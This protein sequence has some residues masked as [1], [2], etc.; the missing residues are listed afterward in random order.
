MK[1]IRTLRLCAALALT[2]A[3]VLTFVACD[4]GFG[5]STDTETEAAGTTAPE[6]DSATETATE[7]EADTGSESDSGSATESASE[8]DPAES[9]SASDSASE[10]DSET[11][12]DPASESGSESETEEPD[13]ASVVD[14]TAGIIDIGTAKQLM[15]LNAYINY[16][17]DDSVYPEDWYGLD[18]QT[19]RLTADIDLAGYEWT[20]L[21]GESLL[22]VVFDGQGHTI[23]NMTIHYNTERDVT[24]N[25]AYLGCGFIGTAAASSYLEIRNVTFEDAYIVARERHVGC[26]VGRNM[27]ANCTFE[28]ITVKNFTVDGWCDYNN[29]SADTDG[30]PIAFRIG[31][32]MGATFDGYQD[33]TRCTVSGMHASGFHNLSGILGYDNT[34][35]VSSLSFE[36]CHVED[37]H[38][39]FSYCLADAYSIDMPRRFVSV[40]FCGSGW[41][42]NLD[43]C[44][45]N[46]NTYADVYYYDWTS[47]D[48]IDDDGNTKNLEDLTR[49][50]A[51]EFRSWTQ[52][53]KEAI[54][55]AS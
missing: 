43:D 47:S 50:E 21:D 22:D 8:L 30:Y 53:E 36:E 4:M 54:E 16:E 20:P 39:V 18:S 34:R 32:I 51:N 46:G 38:F 49:Y 41:I 5:T 26:V 29:G 14:M 13:P 7:A 3:L 31:G 28:D 10:S 35:Q 1:R 45:E 27:G 44:L 55:A 2:L 24:G 42:D 9:D 48:E 17:L 25:T 6:A 19:V 33:F 11:E 52:E 37:A 23:K 12:N 40:F 15:Y